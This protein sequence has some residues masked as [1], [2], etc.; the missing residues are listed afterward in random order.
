MATYR[1]KLAAQK[2]VENGGNIGKAMSAAG[3]SP[4]TAKG[5]PRWLVCERGSG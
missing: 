2:L 1:Q 4:A 5:S 3:Y